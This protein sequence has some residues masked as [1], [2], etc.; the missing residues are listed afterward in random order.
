MHNKAKTVAYMGLMLTLV[1][2]LS[3]FE[4]MLPPLPML[5][6]GM[7]LGL[8]NIVI[9]YC[10]FFWGGKWAFGVAILKSA[11]VVLMRGLVAGF[12]S[13][14]GGL[15][16]VAVIVILL[17]LFKQRLS[18]LA[19]GVCGAVAHN[20]GQ[21]TA[22]SL[23]LSANVFYYTPV[24]ILSGIIMGSL[25]GLTLCVLMPVLRRML[26]SSRGGRSNEQEKI[27]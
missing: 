17:A 4:H 5:P 1:L 21:I 13:L 6:P 9:M 25:T 15:L 8:S 14:S 16:S 3:F 12:L 18:Y 26:A 19:A 11:F 7:N 22:A 24:L 10:I 2:T 20:I 27:K 23:I